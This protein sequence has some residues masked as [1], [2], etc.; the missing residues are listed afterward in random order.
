MQSIQ[1]NSPKKVVRMQGGSDEDEEHEKE[2][3]LITNLTESNKN[4][5]SLIVRIPSNMNKF[6]SKE[7][8]K[9]NFNEDIKVP[10]KKGSKKLRSFKMEPSAT[11]SCEQVSEKTM[12]NT[13]GSPDVR[14]D[15]TYQSDGT[16]GGATPRNGFIREGADGENGQRDE[17]SE[18]GDDEEEDQEEDE[19]SEELIKSFK[20][21]YV[22]KHQTDSCNE[23]V[24]FLREHTKNELEYFLQK[25]KL[26]YSY[27]MKI[28]DIINIDYDKLNE[29][30]IIPYFLTNMFDAEQKR[31]REK[32]KQLLEA[33]RNCLLERS[34]RRYNNQM[35]KGAAG[36]QK[37]KPK[38]SSKGSKRTKGEKLHSAKLKKEKGA[39]GK[40]G[41]KDNSDY[42]ENDDENDNQDDDAD[43]EDDADGEDISG[44]KGH[45]DGGDDTYEPLSTRVKRKNKPGAKL[46]GVKDKRTRTK[47]GDKQ[48]DPYL[49]DFDKDADV[50]NDVNIYNDPTLYGIEG[51]SDYTEGL[52]SDLENSQEEE[53]KDQQPMGNISKEHKKKKKM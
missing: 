47:E 30:N 38:L 16:D 2:E 33:K 21:N 53:A 26:H 52:K 22:E 40:G 42:D 15:T 36:C 10:N 12:E 32:L 18:S 48:E 20:Q 24:T 44:R 34:K 51:S 46:V 9:I 7:E 25:R 23:S 45:S 14:V 13:Y 35:E 37:G 11:G 17:N 43:D 28:N 49:D 50:D 29:K 41:Q 3:Y 1:V 6:L 19:M 4:M 5:P 27:E 31:K 8:V 39:N